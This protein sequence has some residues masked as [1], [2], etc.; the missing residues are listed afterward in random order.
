[1]EIKKDPPHSLFFC[2]ARQNSHIDEYARLNQ[3][4]AQSHEHGSH[5]RKAR[6]GKEGKEG[7]DG[8]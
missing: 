4:P 5:G 1:M 6:Q 7:K 8:C 2:F 3:S